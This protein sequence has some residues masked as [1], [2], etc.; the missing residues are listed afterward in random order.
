M[1]IR[2]EG[3]GSL[4]ERK[5]MRFT[6]AFSLRALSNLLLISQAERT[7]ETDYE[8]AREVGA[9]SWKGGN[10]KEVN[11]QIFIQINFMLLDNF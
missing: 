7:Q 6:P 11:P 4:R 5:Y 9:K 3:L 8:T 10:Y 2:F 1:Q